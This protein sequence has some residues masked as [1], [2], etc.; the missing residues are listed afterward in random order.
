VAVRNKEKIV[1]GNKNDEG[2][3]PLFFS[4]PTLRGSYNPTVRNKGYS[5]G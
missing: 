2:K 1:S 5:V 3:Y 4:Y